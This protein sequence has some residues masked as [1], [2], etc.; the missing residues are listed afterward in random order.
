MKT[1]A[2]RVPCRVTQ[3]AQAHP[4]PAG[5]GRRSHH[6][7]GKLQQLPLGLLHTLRVPLDTDQVALLTV[8]RDAHGHLVLVFD[9]VYLITQQETRFRLRIYYVP[10]V[11]NHLA[12]QD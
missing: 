6:P 8:R 1:E 5:P 3:Q 2:Q 11:I 12:E 9:S 10:L 7:R 4:S